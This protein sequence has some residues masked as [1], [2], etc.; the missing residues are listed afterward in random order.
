[1]EKYIFDMYHCS[2]RIMMTCWRVEAHLRPTFTELSNDIEFIVNS[3]NGQQ[4]S[5]ASTMRTN[6]DVAVF[7]SNDVDQLALG[8]LYRN[9]GAVDGAFLP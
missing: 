5:S 1:M 7:Y 6:D 3:A 2:Y 4:P 8:L 9:S